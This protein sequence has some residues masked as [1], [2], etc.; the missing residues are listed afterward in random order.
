MVV[1][2][3]Y[4]NEEL[5]YHGGNDSMKRLLSIGL[6]IVLTVIL[7]GCGKAGDLYQ[8]GKKSFHSGNYED[9]AASFA[10]AVEKNPNRADY[11]IDYGLTLI[12]LGKYEEALAEFDK[13][14]VSK[15]IIIAKRN[16]KR[17]FRGK[18]IAY[19]YMADYEK[20]LEQFEL[21]L[22]MKELSDLNHDIFLYVGSAQMAVGAYDMAAETY[23]VLM[24][25][26]KEGAAEYDSRALCYRYL[27]E[28]DKSQKD[29]DKAIALEPRQYNHY[30]GK[31]YLLTERGDAAAA[32]EV[33]I[34][35][36]EIEAKTG[37]DKYQLAKVHYYQEEYD[38][39]LSEL[40]ESLA[41]GFQE[42]NYYIG[43]IYRIKKDYPKA[44]YYYENYI[45]EG[46]LQSPNIYNQI[47]VCELKVGDYENA[48]N[49]LEKGL[50]FHHVS[51]QKTLLRNEII[52]YERLGNYQKANEKTEE[53]LS[54]YPKDEEALKE[55]AFIDT[56]LMNAVIPMEE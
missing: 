44:I 34:K 19:Y 53:Y 45:K 24:K 42:A 13:A 1:L 23:T 35:A 41:D 51:M 8:N 7:C 55:A 39:A 4:T 5:T 17:V 32:D 22:K 43:E 37:E 27:G 29:Y 18:G 12:K 6:C 47:A 11:Y 2:V 25:N 20:A 16:N 21:A 26:E 33:L 14:Y 9:A 30:L 49:Y 38:K 54:L 28:Y 48:L 36:A 50:S 31:Y 10:A 15:E 40:N 52:T 56:R 46:S 3:N